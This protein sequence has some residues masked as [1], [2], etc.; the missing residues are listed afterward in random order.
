[1]SRYYT[2]GRFGEEVNNTPYYSEFPDDDN[3]Q[4]EYNHMDNSLRNRNRLYVEHNMDLPEFFTQNNVDIDELR[5]EPE[6]GDYYSRSKYNMIIDSARNTI[7]EASNILQSYQTNE[8]R[9]YEQQTTY[10]Q[11]E[12][13]NK[14]HNTV[15]RNIIGEYVEQP[16]QHVVHNQPHKPTQP[17]HKSQPQTHTNQKTKKSKLHNH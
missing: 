1:M 15:A 3:T 6:T 16:K 11:S 9:P 13:G 8:Y 4:T 12:L 7:L 5:E 14:Y 2:P 10:Q 17:V